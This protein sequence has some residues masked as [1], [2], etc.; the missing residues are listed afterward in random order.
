M[1]SRPRVNAPMSIAQRLDTRFSV[2]LRVDCATRDMR[3]AH[4]VTNI[5]RGGLFVEGSSLPIDSELTLRLHLAE[6]DVMQVKARVVWNYDIEGTSLLVRGMGMKFVGLSAE[7]L[8]RLNA[9][10]KK[11]APRPLAAAS[12][13]HH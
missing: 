11:L 2:S 6:H 10:L 12:S 1:L 7:E 3:R 8:R 13:T 4:R 9:Y 5:G